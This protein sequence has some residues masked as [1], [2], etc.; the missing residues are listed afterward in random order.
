MQL[1][2]R[3]IFQP[4]P[5]AFAVPSNLERLRVG[6]WWVFLVGFIFFPSLLFKRGTSAGRKRGGVPL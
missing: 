1:R 2:V 3:C 5:P 6:F 4:M